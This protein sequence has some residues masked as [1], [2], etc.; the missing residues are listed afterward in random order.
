MRI[1][2]SCRNCDL[3]SEPLAYCPCK[4]IMRD[5]FPVIEEPKTDSWYGK[6]MPSCKQL[7]AL[8]YCSIE[9]GYSGAYES[10]FV[11]CVEKIATTNAIAKS[12]NFVFI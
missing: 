10:L 8:K 7:P 9:E 5:D 12:L 6:V 4:T 1:I 3:L 2:A 11:H